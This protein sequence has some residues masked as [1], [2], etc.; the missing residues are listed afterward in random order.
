MVAIFVKFTNDN[1]NG[2]NTYTVID[3]AQYRGKETL[4]SNL[5]LKSFKDLDSECTCSFPK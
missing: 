3:A 5:F 2:D 4:I 1:K